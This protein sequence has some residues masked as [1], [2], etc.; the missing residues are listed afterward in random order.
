MSVPTAEGVSALVHTAIVAFDAQ[1]PRTIQS[2]DG[3][4]GPSDLGWCRNKTAL[5]IK[6]VRQSDSKSIW[7]AVIGTALGEYVEKSIKFMFPTWLVGSVDGIRV[8]YTSLNGD[9][10]SGTPDVIAPDFNLLA[11]LKSKDGFEWEMRKGSSTSNKYQRHAYAKGA[12]AAGIL[13]GDRPV[14]VANIY[15]DRSGNIE[16]PLSEVQELDPMLDD[17]IT[18]WIE[19]VK[20]AVMHGEDASRDVAA[21]ICAS[22][23]EFF[24]VC[25]GG[26]PASESDVYTDPDIVEA[27][28][29]Y[30]DGRE[31]ATEGERQRKAAAKFLTGLNGVADGWQVRTTDVDATDVPGFYRRG[32]TK[33]EIVKA[34]PA[35]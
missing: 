9:E 10:I 13:D 26:L 8:T 14:Y 29:M 15:I 11:D 24:T 35:K 31:M 5:T 6:G 28:H 34:R 30:L 18:Q 17:E 19:D 21:P 3:I 1:R 22:I 2:R 12:V 20:Y 23:C 33:V 27:V 7:P 4:I 32:Y 16:M 25:R